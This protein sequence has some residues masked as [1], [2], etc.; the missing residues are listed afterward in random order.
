MPG[1]CRRLSRL[2]RRQARMETHSRPRPRQTNKSTRVISRG[3]ARDWHYPA[4]AALCQTPHWRG[5][6]PRHRSGPFPGGLPVVFRLRRRCAAHGNRARRAD[7]GGG[8]G[9]R[10]GGAV[11][12]VLGALPLRA[13]MSTVATL[14]VLAVL[15]TSGDSAVQVPGMMTTGGN[16]DP[17]ARIKIVWGLLVA[18][19]AVGLLPA[20]GSRCMSL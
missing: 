13:V 2:F 1:R 17:P 3:M 9:G 15:I 18:G 4:I 7:R 16:P 19:I 14:L 5:A 11:H 6:Q 8:R 20:G 12:A 10:A